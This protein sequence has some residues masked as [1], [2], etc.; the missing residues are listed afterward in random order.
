ML[1]HIPL[2]ISLVSRHFGIDT[3]IELECLCMVL[4]AHIT[5]QNQPLGSVHGVVVKMGE[6]EKLLWKIQG[7]FLVMSDCF[8][9]FRV[10]KKVTISHI[11]KV[12]HGYGADI[13]VPTNCTNEDRQIFMEKVQA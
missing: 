9:V 11:S 5:E 8:V 1:A 2:C 12:A 7:K 13:L 3:A 6:A 10:N 4:T